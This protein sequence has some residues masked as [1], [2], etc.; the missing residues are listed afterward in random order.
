[1]LSP[2]ARRLSAVLA[3][4]FV[5][6]VALAGEPTLPG[7]APSEP[8]QVEQKPIASKHTTQKVAKKA[9]KASHKRHHKKHVKAAAKPS[10]R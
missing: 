8:V 7:M 6:S 4:A 9:K 5:S 1:M 3:A 2:A 10:T